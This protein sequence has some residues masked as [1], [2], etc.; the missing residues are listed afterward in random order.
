MFGSILVLASSV[1]RA[2]S[3]YHL[4]LRDPHF[5]VICVIFV[6]LAG[7]QGGTSNR[8]RDLLARILLAGRCCTYSGLYKLHRNR[9]NETRDDLKTV[10]VTPSKHAFEQ[11]VGRSERKGQR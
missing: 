7:D 9:R 5:S 6:S 2:A 8:S 11:L 10:V 4:L 3:K 1:A